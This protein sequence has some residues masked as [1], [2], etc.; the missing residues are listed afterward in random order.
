[1]YIGDTNGDHVASK[2]NIKFAYASLG[3]GK[4]DDHPDYYLD[5]ITEL[6]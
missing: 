2:N 1:M 3:Y 6:I 4:C 5:N